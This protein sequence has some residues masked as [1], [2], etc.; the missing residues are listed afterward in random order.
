MQPI[1]LGVIGVGDIS[2][3]YLSTI[4]RSPALKLKALATRRPDLIAEKARELGV[5]ACHV[6]QLLDDPE[7]E[8]VV[9]L[10]P[11]VVHEELNEQIL[12]AGKHLYCEK[13][14]ALDLDVAEKLAAIARERGLLIGSAP[15]TF[16]GSAHQASRRALDAGLIGEPVFGQSFVGL[17]GLELFHPNPAQFYESGGEAPYD[18]GPYYILQWIHLL[19]PVRR[20]HCAVERRAKLTPLAG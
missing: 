13:P 18:S 7:V 3:V 11:G 1:C 12:R 19:G 17:P 10:T 16:F 8:L 2:E 5:R 4:S 9:N 15:D 6:E 20:V 14:F